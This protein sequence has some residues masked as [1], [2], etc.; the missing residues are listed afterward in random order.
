MPARGLHAFVE[1]SNRIE[2]IHRPPTDYE[3]RAHEW[4]LELPELRVPELELFVREVAAVPLRRAAGQNVIVG[5]HTPPPG[6]P[7]IEAELQELLAE[8]HADELTPW[9][10]H[11]AYEKLHPF[12]DGNGRSGRALWAW[13][14]LREGRNPF[15]RGFLH[16]AYYEA[17]EAGRA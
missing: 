4:L 10:A 6:G 3:I 16:A 7:E 5:T 1:E 9:E 17:L 11:V 12:L 15:A 8:I 13:M 14:I 2:S